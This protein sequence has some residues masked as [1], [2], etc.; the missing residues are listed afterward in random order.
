MAVAYSLFMGNLVLLPLWLQ[1]FMGYTSTQAGMLMA[2]VGLF[3][4]ILSPVVGKNIQKFDPR[5][6]TTFA[7]LVFSAVLFMRSHFNTQADFGTVMFPTIV[8][9]VAVAFFFIPLT[10]I[11]LGGIAPERIPSA[12]GLSSYAPRAT[13]RAGESGKHGNHCCV[14]GF[15][16]RWNDHRTGAVPD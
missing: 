6:L 14:D 2:P 16:C 12:S 13:C 10:T 1:Q 5:T 15:Q 9:G 7:F 3:A 4:I 11:T 8:Q